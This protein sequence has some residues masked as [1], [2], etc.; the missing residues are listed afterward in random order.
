M[1]RSHRAFTLIELLVVIAVIGILIALLLPAVQAAREAARRTECANHLKQFG[2]A[3]HNHH[4]SHGFLPTVVAIGTTHPTMTRMANRKLARPNGP[5]G[6]FQIL[7]YMEQ[8]SLWL[9]SGGTTNAER[10][11]IAIGNAGKRIF[12]SIPAESSFAWERCELVCARRYV[13]PFTVRL[14]GQQSR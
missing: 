12:L 13:S 10:Q 6:V 7:P 4:D 14:R 11:Q 2:L 1:V 3:F 5:A 9:G 8:E